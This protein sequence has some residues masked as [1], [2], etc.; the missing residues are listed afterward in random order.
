M[1]SFPETSKPDNAGTE[2]NC[3]VLCRQQTG[4]TGRDV[5]R[6]LGLGAARVPRPLLWFS[7]RFW[8]RRGTNNRDDAPNCDSHLWASTRARK[9]VL[10]VNPFLKSSWY[11]RDLACAWRLCW[12]HE[13]KHMHES[14]QMYCSLYKLKSYFWRQQWKTTNIFQKA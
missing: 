12:A 3:R 5:H 11:Q 9:H 4:G 7:R 6:A 10:T 13:L 14:G 1:V 8:P 2:R